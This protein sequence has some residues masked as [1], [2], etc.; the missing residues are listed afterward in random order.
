[1]EMPEIAETAQAKL[2]APQ[3]I[4]PNTPAHVV[5]D[6]QDKSSGKPITNFDLFQTKLM[7]LIVFSDNLQAFSHIHPIYQNKGRFDVEANFPQP[8]GYTL[9]SDYK[10]TGQKEQVSVMKTQVL[11]ISPVASPINLSQTRTF[12]NTKA[13]LT[14]PEVTLKA[15]QEIPLTFDLQDKLNNQPINDLQPYLGEKGHLVIVRQA[16][17]LSRSDYIHAHAAKDP[18]NSRAQFMTSFPKPGRYK[19]WG[20]FN[21][22]GKIVIADFWVNV[23]S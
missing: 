14:F 19:L 18:S 6:V 10:P 12:G 20:Q 23:S 15:G 22:N 17:S 2:T 5:I 13:S 11:G 8:G 7:H 9:F 4:T 1:M 21:R 3:R 16:P